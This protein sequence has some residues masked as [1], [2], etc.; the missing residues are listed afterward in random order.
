ML[1]I[2]HTMICAGEQYVLAH[3]RCAKFHV[4][5]AI[6][7][8]LKK[9]FS[10]AHCSLFLVHWHTSFSASRPSQ[11]L[12]IRNAPWQPLKA[13]TRVALS[14]MSAATSSQPTSAYSRDTRT[15]TGVIRKESISQHGRNGTALCRSLDR[16]AWEFSVLSLDRAAAWE[17]LFRQHIKNV[18]LTAIALALS[19]STLRV[20][21]RIAN[22]PFLARARATAPPCWPEIPT[23]AIMGFDICI[24]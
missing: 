22:F 16:A 2:T 1:Y 4:L 12:V 8:K 6:C 15:H 7:T 9:E 17:I 14:F 24:M 20:I 10:K 18:F 13:S 11:K 23:T 3:V 5:K 21:P 19:A